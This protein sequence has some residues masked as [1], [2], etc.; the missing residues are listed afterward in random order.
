MSLQTPENHALYISAMNRTKPTLSTNNMQIFLAL[1][2]QKTSGTT[3]N[4]SFS[5]TPASFPPLFNLAGTTAVTFVSKAKVFNQK[6]STN[7]NLD[8][9]G[10]IPLTHPFSASFS[11]VLEFLTLTFS[12]TA[13]AEILGTLTDLMECL[14]LFLKTLLHC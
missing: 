5:F 2:L 11:L 3:K 9:S 13:L 10:Y 6:I 7:S 8:D 14:L 12:V 4:I 1:I